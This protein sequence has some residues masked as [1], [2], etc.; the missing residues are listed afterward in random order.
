MNTYTIYK[1]KDIYLIFGAAIVLSIAITGVFYATLM[2]GILFIY[3]YKSSG[4]NDSIDWYFYAKKDILHTLTLVCFISFCF[5]Y[6]IFEINIK[7]NSLSLSINFIS[8]LI[9]IAAI[10]GIYQLPK[11]SPRKLEKDYPNIVQERMYDDILVQ[12]D[13]AF[14]YRVVEKKIDMRELD[15]SV[16]DNERQLKP[17]IQKEIMDIINRK[18]VNFYDYKLTKTTNIEETLNFLNTPIKD[19]KER[20]KFIRYIFQTCNKKLV[21]L[22]EDFDFKQSLK[23]YSNIIEYAIIELFLHTRNYKNVPMANMIAYANESAYS[24]HLYGV[25]DS[26]T[27][28]S[29]GRYGIGYYVGFHLF[30]EYITFTNLNQHEEK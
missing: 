10:Y 24:K 7:N 13:D 21:P 11:M 14:R 19:A 16:V 27:A 29:I 9:V 25:L 1:T 3:I 22:K 18:R 30:N 12:L 6:Y 8:I 2:M 17:S 23:K 20:D 5:M 4:T 28:T 26:H 15:I